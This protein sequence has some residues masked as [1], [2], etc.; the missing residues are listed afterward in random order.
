MVGHKNAR[1][2]T[3]PAA[4]YLSIKDDAR[5]MAANIAELPEG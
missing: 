1:Q 4:R 2:A 3:G 5:R